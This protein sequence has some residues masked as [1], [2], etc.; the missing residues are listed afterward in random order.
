MLNKLITR[1]S[2]MKIYNT[3][4][5]PIRYKNNEY[6]ERGK[7]ISEVWNKKLC[8]QYWDQVKSQ[9]INT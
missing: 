2:K 4:I 6:D 7:K 1:E 3:I 9:K 8:Q 5:R